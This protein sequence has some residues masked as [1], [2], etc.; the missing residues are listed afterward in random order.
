LFAEVP[1]AKEAPA[2]TDV[3]VPAG[4]LAWPTLFQPQHTSVPS[5][6]MPQV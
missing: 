5:L 3:N 2:L 1:Q 4:G 6:L